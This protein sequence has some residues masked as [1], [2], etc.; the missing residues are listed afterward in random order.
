MT[1]ERTLPYY[2]EHILPRVKKGDNVLVAAH[3]NSLRCVRHR[4]LVPVRFFITAQIDHHA[5]RR[6]QREGGHRA[7]AGDRAP[8]FGLEY[9][10]SLDNAQGVP[11][12]YKMDGAQLLAPVSSLPDDSTAEAGKVQVCQLLAN[13]GL[14]DPGLPQEKKI[15]T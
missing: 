13:V 7:R 14:T 15:L 2:E 4:G 10:L 12:V 6:P 11:T 3:G 1:A 5:D 9:A 8:G